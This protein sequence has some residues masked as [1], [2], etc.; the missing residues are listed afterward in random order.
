MHYMPPP[1]PPPP[2]PQ[3]EKVRYS[4]EIST[5]TTRSPSLQYRNVVF[6]WVNIFYTSGY[7]L[8]PEHIFTHP[9]NS[10]NTSPHFCN[11]LPHCMETSV[12]SYIIVYVH[13]SHHHPLSQPLYTWVVHFPDCYWQRR[14]SCRRWLV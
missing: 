4:P 7:C 6:I 14:S 13:K 5:T 11:I 1:P 12:I 9:L 8:N 2:P 10:L 3:M